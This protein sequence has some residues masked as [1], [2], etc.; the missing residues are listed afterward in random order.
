MD[1]LYSNDQD[2]HSF[3]SC[4]NGIAYLIQCQSNLIFN[5]NIL[6]CDW[7]NGGDND[8]HCLD[9]NLIKFENASTYAKIPNGYHGLKWTNVYVL[10]TQI[11][12]Q[13]SESGFYSALESGTWVAFNL[14][15]ERMTISI[16]APYKFSIKSFVVSSAWND[17]VMLSLVSQRAS[18]YYREASFKIEK[19]YSTLIELNWI[20]IDT[21]TFFATT[22]DSRNGEVF[23]IDDLCLD[24]TTTATSTSVTTGIIHQCPSNEV[25]YQNHCYYLDGIGGQ[26]AY[27]YSLGSETVLSR[28][29]DLFI[30]LNYRTAI[31]DNCCV[32]TS[33]KYLNFGIA[34]LHQC[35]KRGPFTTVPVLNGGGCTNYTNKH[36]KQLT[37]CVSH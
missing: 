12:P 25:L 7:D 21:I 16:D 4:S 14:N 33:E 8:K 6:A 5:Q 34:K 28:I 13:W 3:Y 19:N 26:C 23:V 24:L 29:A 17:N 10:D 11:Y 9:S 30:G 35:N 27:G 20:D 31:S 1:G 18:T 36:P 2:K 22:N 15:G 37:F 32:V